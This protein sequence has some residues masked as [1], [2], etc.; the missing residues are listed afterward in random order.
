MLKKKNN[1]CKLKKELAEVD[2][3][4]NNNDVRDISMDI[5]LKRLEIIDNLTDEIITEM[6]DL[7]KIK[8]S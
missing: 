5:L 1:V 8:R 3:I 7:S 6:N 2:N 4:I